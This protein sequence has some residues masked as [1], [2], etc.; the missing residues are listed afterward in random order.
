MSEEEEKKECKHNDWYP[1]CCEDDGEKLKLINE[2]Y[3]AICKKCGI[4]S[5]IPES[6]L[7]CI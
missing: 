2:H 4:Q 6:E 3:M 5:I 1:L 7:K